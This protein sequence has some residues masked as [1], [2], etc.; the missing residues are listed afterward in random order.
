MN[1]SRKIAKKTWII[2]G[3]AVIIACIVFYGATRRHTNGATSFT[4]AKVERG[5]I[6]N[7][8]SSTGALNAK[9]TVEVGTQ[10][11]G[12][13]DKVYVDYN[14]HVR[15]NQILAVLDSTL[16]AA[17]VRDAQANLLKT[18]AQYDLSLAKYEDTRELYEQDF[19]SEI[20][21]KTAETDYA[22]ARA[23]LLSAQATL[24]RAKADL[25]Y[26]VIR[27]PINGT[28]IDRSVEPGQTVAASFSTPTLFVI[29]EDLSQ[30]E[31]HA[32]VDESD[33]GHIKEGQQVRFTVDAFPDET[34][35]GTVR[36]IR[37]QPETIDN[38]VNYTVVVDAT[39]DKELLLPGMTATVDF[40]IEQRMDVLVISNSALHIQPTET[41]LAE[42]RENMRE[43]ISQVPDSVRQLQIQ[44]SR[45]RQQAAES[46]V[47]DSTGQQEQ[48]EDIAMLWYYDADK[49]LNVMPVHTGITD[50]KH[51]EIL[52]SHG[53]QEGM[54]YIS[55][56]GQQGESETASS[57]QEQNRPPRLPHF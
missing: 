24:E 31:I 29:A 10:V 48:P 47:V 26:A 53:I 57:N 46:A 22:A 33:I 43:K 18:Q 20:D 6:E 34:F 45:N 19:V 12:T 1:R 9:G 52:E 55:G 8:I 23:G 49:K 21:Y 25:K 7:T 51:T 39:N 4:F 11:S 44:E 41:M 5:D 28:V 17:S 50:G 56:I 2:I 14:D 38:V 13:I 15:K 16:L 42:A 3:I 40:L 30:M 37:L 27:S 32:F 54:E 35:T 36:Q